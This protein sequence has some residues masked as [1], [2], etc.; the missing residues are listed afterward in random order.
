MRHT[1]L[2]GGYQTHTLRN[3]AKMRIASK[4]C[5]RISGIRRSLCGLSSIFFAVARFSRR[6]EMHCLRPTQQSGFPLAI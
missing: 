6:R 4:V 5:P 1:A 3:S 2:D